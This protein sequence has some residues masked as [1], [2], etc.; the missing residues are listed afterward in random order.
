LIIDVRSPEE[1]QSNHL[2]KAINIP[3]RD[4]RDTLPSRVKD[5]SQVLLLHCLSG[6]R[7][8]IARHKLK[9]MGYPKVFNLGSLARARK[10]VER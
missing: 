7:S 6:G 1:F 8:G 4:L 5:K 10:I 9:S 3:L 2:A